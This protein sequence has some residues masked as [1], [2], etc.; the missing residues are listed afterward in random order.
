M[1]KEE[2]GG[3]RMSLVSCP[4]NQ[5]D[6]VYRVLIYDGHQPGHIHVHKPPGSTNTTL[7][8]NSNKDNDGM[9]IICTNVI[10]LVDMKLCQ[11]NH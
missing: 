5:R 8:N 11:T 1:T 6:T 10:R 3:L 7:T 9:L 4:S 2:E